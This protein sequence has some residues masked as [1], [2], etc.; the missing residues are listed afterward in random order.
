[1]YCGYFKLCF[2]SKL[3]VQGKCQ[4]SREFG[5][6]ISRE[7][8]FQGSNGFRLASLIVD[9]SAQCIFVGLEQIFS[10]YQ[11]PLSTLLS[12]TS[13]TCSVMK[14]SRNGFIAKLRELQ[15]T[16][17]DISCICYSLNLCVKS[18][19]KTLLLKI[20]KLFVDI[21]Y[22]FRHSVKLVSLLQE[23]AN[24][25]SCEYKAVL[26]H[27]E[28]R[29]LSLRRAVMRTLQ[30]WQSL[31]SYFS[32]HPDVEKSGKVRNISKL[33]N[34][35]ITKPWLSFLSNILGIFDKFNIV[36]QTYSTSLIHKTQSE[37]ARLLRKVISFFVSPDVIL[38]H[39]ED[40][41]A[42]DYTSSSN[43]L[44]HESVYIGD[45]T[46]ALLLQLQDEGQETESFYRAV[47][48]FYTAF[49]QK[50][51]KV[52]KFRSS[53]WPIFSFLDPHQSRQITVSQFDDIERAISIPFDKLQV[54]LE[55][56]E[57]V[58]DPEID[59]TERD[60]IQFWL[61]VNIM[62]SPLGRRKYHHLSI[63]A[64]NLLSISASNADSERVFSF[65]TRIKTNFRTSLST[66]TVS[67]LIGC[68]LNNTFKCCEQRKCDNALLNR[69]QTCIHERNQQYNSALD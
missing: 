3:S 65:V 38:D 15:P 37:T 34:D 39:V 9:C 29:W 44:L 28:T 57:F 69:A 67:A 8:Y 11:I 47:T 17:I 52:H 18:T 53:L 35:P 13:D 60:A 61:N 16:L 32:S 12:F 51:L 63:L 58:T 68:H 20:D 42:V 24:F 4:I 46:I 10:R 59:A 56:R 64:L 7:I 55:A 1:M 6:Y 23:Y 2:F 54:K 45:Y 26:K 22:H 25:C 49:A 41:V 27:C 5:R 14:R 19:V 40:L 36:F 48:V 66:E 33:L 30:I 21:F 31:V 43:H 50:L 62:E